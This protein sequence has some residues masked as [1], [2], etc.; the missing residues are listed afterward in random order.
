[1]VASLRNVSDELAA[2]VASGLGMKLPL[3]MPTALKRAPN[4]E[5]TQSAAL[6]LTALPGDGGIRTRRIAVL[7]AD[8]VKAESVAMLVSALSKAGAVPN[9][10][11]SRLGAIRSVDGQEFQVNAT[12]ETM[13]SVLFDAMAL[14]DGEQAVSELAGDGHTIEF[15]KDQ[16]RHGKTIFVGSA[17]AQLL[18]EAGIESALPSGAADAGVIL[19]SPARLANQI[20]EFVRAIG[21]HRHPGREKDPPV[22]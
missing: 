5:V 15:I 6:S 21:K 19:S 8:G 16:Y 12:F 1:M 13:P 20:S 10:I 11:S 18:A 14:P 17:S 7:V 2:A 4:A 3:P 22:V 9:L